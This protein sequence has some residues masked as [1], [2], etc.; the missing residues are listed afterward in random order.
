MIVIIISFRFEDSMH[1]VVFDNPLYCE[2][3]VASSLNDDAIKN[4]HDV[5]DTDQLIIDTNN[6]NV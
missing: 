1:T 4:I 5:T 6:N 3:D 2:P